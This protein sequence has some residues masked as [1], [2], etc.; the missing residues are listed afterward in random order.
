MT[1]F[2]EH[3]VIVVD[4]KT[5]ENVKITRYFQAE[6]SPNISFPKDEGNKEYAGMMEEVNAGTST[7]EEVEDTL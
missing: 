5:G 2:Y 6:G 3:Y 4:S 1:K 7:I